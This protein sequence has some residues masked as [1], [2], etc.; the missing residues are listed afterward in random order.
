M[1]VG[2][3][4]FAF[5]AV[6][7]L[8]SRYG[9]TRQRAV[10]LGVVAALFATIPDVDM[11][12]ALVALVGVDPTQPI[13]AAESFWSASTQV[14][15]AVTHSLV[16]AVP[17]AAAFALT[18]THR[19]VAA[20]VLVALVAL[21]G[22]VTGP[23][24]AAVMALFAVAGWLVATASHRVG[25]HGRSLFVV[26]LAGLASHPFGDLLTGH[27][28]QFLYPLDAA[29]FG[30]RV[31]LAADPTLHLLGAFAVELAAVWIGVLALVH[32]SELDLREHVNAR[33]A[34]G[35]AYALAALVIP[36][37]TLAGSYQFVFSV[38]AVSVVGVV[39]LENHRTVS[40]PHP[41]TALLTGLAAVTLGGVA[42]ATVYLGGL[43]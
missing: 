22:V 10:A 14:H 2:H 19:R 13:A 38:L 15:R 23:L 36:P 31:T 18:P 12:Y 41:W 32:L 17:S 20:G 42:Y 6:A 25:V 29:V 8:S 35:A 26:A 5:G 27:P 4:A 39:P 1:F 34:A 21:A 37:P 30:S 43:A 24:A 3:A 33:A 28:P 40:T 16:V 11:A 9:A 7:L